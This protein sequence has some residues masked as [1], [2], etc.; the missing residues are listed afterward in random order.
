MNDFMESLNPHNNLKENTHILTFVFEYFAQKDM[1]KPID[2]PLE[3]SC[4]FEYSKSD[5]L[6][7]IQIRR[8]FILKL[9]VF[10][11]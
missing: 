4:L 5:G 1:L 7:I 11:P 3:S 6:G 8:I 9:F 2:A 10:S